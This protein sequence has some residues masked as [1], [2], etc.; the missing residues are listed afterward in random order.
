MDNL[1][2]FARRIAESV[3]PEWQLIPDPNSAEWQKSFDSVVDA[4]LKG[5]GAS[6]DYYKDITTPVA[7]LPHANLDGTTPEERFALACRIH[8][9]MEGLW[10]AGRRNID[11]IEQCARSS[12]L[13]LDDVVSY[14]LRLRGTTY[15]PPEN[16]NVHDPTQHYDMF[17]RYHFLGMPDVAQMHA[18]RLFAL[19]RLAQQSSAP[20]VIFEAV[21]EDM[22]R[23]RLECATPGAE[24]HYQTQ[25]VNTQQINPQTGQPAVYTTAPA[26]YDSTKKFNFKT[27]CNPFVVFAWSTCEGL[28]PSEMV[29][30]EYVPPSVAKQETGAASKKTFG[31]FLGRERK[32]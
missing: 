30:A 12:P 32:S 25:R 4:Y 10:L 8:A 14:A 31:F 9:I 3:K 26:I 22:H 24:V 21:G 7:A 2:V 20:R 18:S 27:I 19:S 23:M 29:K 16:M 6:C 1:E 13:K 15:S 5:E 11:A 28:R 17:P